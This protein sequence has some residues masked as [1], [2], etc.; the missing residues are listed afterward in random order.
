MLTI[1][2]GMGTVRLAHFLASCLSLTASVK[3]SVRLYSPPIVNRGSTN[4]HYF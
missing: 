2:A 1:A 3:K 4:A